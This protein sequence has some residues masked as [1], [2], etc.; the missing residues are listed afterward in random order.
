MYC[1][2]CSCE[3]TYKV[4]STYNTKYVSVPTK[5]RQCSECG[6][7]WVSTVRMDRDLRMVIEKLERI[8]EEYVP[9]IHEDFV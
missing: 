1:A 5:Y 8:I 6:E 2:M 4:F 3:L 9:Y 7:Q